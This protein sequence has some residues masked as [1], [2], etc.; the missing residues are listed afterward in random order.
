MPGLNIIINSVFVDGRQRQQFHS[1]PSDYSISPWLVP[2]RL[3]NGT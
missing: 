1:K 2:K 3:P